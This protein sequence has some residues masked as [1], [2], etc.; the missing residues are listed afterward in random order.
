M[1][2]WWNSVQ[3][4]VSVFVGNFILLPFVLCVVQHLRKCGKCRQEK[5]QEKAQE[6]PE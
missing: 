3:H 4:I 6:S 1:F 5:E 2:P